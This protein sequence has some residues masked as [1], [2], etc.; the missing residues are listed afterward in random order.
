MMQRPSKSRAW[1]FAIAGGLLLLAG[2]WFFVCVLYWGWVS[3][4]PDAARL[5]AT[6]W[7]NLYCAGVPV[8]LGASVWCFLLASR[9]WRWRPENG[10]CDDCGYDRR[11]LAAD[12]K[13]PECGKANR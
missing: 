2:G 4:T 5:S 10:V 9:R 8:A 1:V 12:A 11:G 7:G 13:C 6:M 3:A